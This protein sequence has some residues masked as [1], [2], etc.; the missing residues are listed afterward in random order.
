MENQLEV[1]VRDSGLEV[2]KAKYILEQFQHFFAL[3][4]EWSIKTKTLVVTRADQTAEMAM[5]REG[6]LFLREQRISVEN[7]RKRLKEE[8]LR[9]CKA[10]DGIANVLKALIVP[11]EEYLD[12]QEHFVERQ[13]EAKRET[14]RI[15]IEARIEAER[16]A[17]EKADAETLEK[18]RIENENLKAE[19]IKR[20]AKAKADRKKQDD[21]LAAEREKAE[22]ARKAQD[23][24]LAKERAKAE[25]ARQAVEAEARAEREKQEKTLANERARDKRLKE[26]AD[27]KARK[28]KA[29]AQKKIDAERTE[30]ERLAE[31]LK[32]QI[33][34]PECGAKFSIKKGAK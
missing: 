26:L 9:E 5:A 4:D 10:I 23:A 22:A 12:Q 2:S 32:N 18:A 24:I 1:I 3:A 11:I 6:R 20:E 21:I 17:K 13:E 16:I 31:I 15:E 34:C 27:E 33:T 30:K 14:M 28:E 19:A 8:A 7:A 29:E 25:A